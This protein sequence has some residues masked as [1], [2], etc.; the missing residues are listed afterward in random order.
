LAGISSQRYPDF[1]RQIEV[2]KKNVWPGGTSLPV[3]K[4]AQIPDAIAS[5]RPVFF[6]AGSQMDNTEARIQAEVE[7]RLAADVA[8]QQNWSPPHWKWW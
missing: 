5:N 1:I 6:S 2:G 3:Q 4:Q 7:K 8:E